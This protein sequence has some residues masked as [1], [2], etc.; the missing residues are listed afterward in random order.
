MKQQPQ[1]LYDLFLTEMWERFSYYGM[2]SLLFLYMIQNLGYSSSIAGSTYGAYTA[3]VYLTA[4]LGGYLADY[5]I[6][7]V[8]SVIIGAILMML[9]HL[10]LAIGGEILFLLSLGF[11]A[12]GT[13]FFK[14]NISVLVGRLYQEHDTRRELGFSLF[15][16]GINLGAFWAPIVCG[17]LGQ[18]VSMN[19]GF[20]AAALGLL[21]GL[22]V[23]I[24][25]LLLGRIPYEK[26]WHKQQPVK[27]EARHYPIALGSVA[28]WV[29][30]LLG[31]VAFCAAFEQAGS[32]M[33]LFAEENTKLVYYG[34][35]IP[36]SWFQSI[37]ALAVVLLSSFVPLL[38]HWLRKRN[39]SITVVRQ[40]LLGL[41]LLTFSYL[42]M[43]Y[44]GFQADQGGRVSGIYLTI[45]FFINTLSEL[46]MMPTGLAT[47]S[48][49]V[50]Q[51]RVGLAMGIWFLIISAGNI[52][53]GN[54]AHIYPGWGR[55]WFFL[56]VS[57][58]PFTSL[59]LLWLLRPWLETQLKNVE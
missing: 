28:L 20:G 37:N 7:A 44:A 5:W 47:I 38:W 50:P 48:H 51:E 19:Y 12:I 26:K 56:L 14:P 13:G 1:A 40:Y 8:S 32:T 21:F 23:F 18:K 6:G 25:S 3:A 30:F 34:F 10:G 2:R 4:I 58:I 33:A 55:G 59:C 46:C 35:S 53:A 15:Y 43:G 39:Y 16:M 45:A 36:S 27:P 11:L 31:N 29:L 42:W 17:T 9:G 24:R 49:Q 22:V 57:A 54:L 41:M 52:L